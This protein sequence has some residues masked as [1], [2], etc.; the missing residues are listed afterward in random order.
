MNKTNLSIV[1]AALLLVA[2]GA[3]LP[4]CRPQHTELPFETI[5]Q[6][7]GGLFYGEEDPNFLVITQ[8]EQVD[9]P[10]LDVQFPS[11]LAEQL[12]AVDYQSRYGD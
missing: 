6:G 8:P 11:D 3:I 10:E 4:A 1:V 2:A 7:S 5:E 12:R 9:A